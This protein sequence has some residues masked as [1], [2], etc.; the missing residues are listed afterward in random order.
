MIVVNHGELERRYNRNGEFIFCG[1]NKAIITKQCTI[2]HKVNNDSIDR[3]E[4]NL[5]KEK[6]F[7]PFFHNFP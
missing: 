4:A 7:F 1:I 2:E 5:K 6:Y 3:I